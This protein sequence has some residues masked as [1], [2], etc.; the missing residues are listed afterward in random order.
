MSLASWRSLQASIRSAGRSPTIRSAWP[1]T[2]RP[3]RP[4]RGSRSARAWCCSSSRG[5][6]RSGCMVSNRGWAALILAAGLL[7]GCAMLEPKPRPA[8]AV[9]VNEDPYPSTY[10]RYPGVP[11]LIRGATIF[12]GD[13]NKLAPGDILIADGVVKA[14]EPNLMVPDGAVV[15]DGTGKYVTPGIIDIH[16]HL[17]DY[18]S[19]GVDSL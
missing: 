17:G 12:D 5:R 10:V 1:L 9:H 8:P 18:P 13:G 15:I 14:V 6:S 16:S 19:P 3:S 2:P 4:S 7:Q 11:T